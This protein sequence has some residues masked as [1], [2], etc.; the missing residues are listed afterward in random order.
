MRPLVPLALLALVAFAADWNP[1][2][3]A[4]RAREASREAN[5]A[6]R[7]GDT[8]AALAAVDRA[9]SAWP[10]QQAYGEAL[11]RLAARRSDTARV[12]RALRTLTAQEIGGGLAND[13][14]LRA[15]AERDAN[16]AAALRALS[17]ANA[18][19]E[20]SV[21]RAI[22]ADTTFF[23]EGLDGDPRSGRLFVTSLHHRNVLVIEPDGRTRWLLSEAREGRGPVFGVAFDAPRNQLWLSTA[24]R[25]HT[26]ALPGDSAVRSE[27]LRVALDG[28][29]R[30]RVLLGDGRSTPGEIAVTGNG[31]VLVS[32]ATRGRLYRLPPGAREVQEIRSPLL[33][34]PQGIAPHPD[35]KSAI[36]ADWSHGLLF[37]SLESDEIT[38]LPM[39][40]G[41]TTLGIDGLRRWGNRLVA[42]QN[43][44]QP[45]RVVLMELSRDGRGLAQL[46]TLD[47]P[48]ELRGEMT[49]GA[50][51]GDRYVYVA[52][53]AW[54]FWEDDG[55]RNP[56]AGALP[57]VILRE[58]AQRP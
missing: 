18:P 9:F 27:L 43:G 4:A 48:A 25:Q 35:G 46:R 45:Q 34:S 52:S 31:T 41:S 58:L 44:V 8:V 33:R 56:R 42:N 22:S 28:S 2:E 55:V 23:P 15:L 51:L 57:P 13:A 7:G 3:L 1:A 29:I 12:L 21:A 19:R 53:S 54:P 49:V 16:V 11:A 39:P 6:I 40:N 30:E 24:P 26:P 50:V 37:W 20:L 47:R 17:A 38:A 32:D 10:A 5:L 14:A 36:V